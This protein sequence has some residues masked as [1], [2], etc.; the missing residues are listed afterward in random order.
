VKATHLARGGPGG[1]ARS[2]GLADESPP[3]DGIAG[4]GDGGIAAGDADGIGKPD[5]VIVPG[6]AAD[7]TSMLDGA[8]VSG[9]ACAATAAIGA[10]QWRQK[11]AGLR[12]CRL[13]TEH[14]AASSKELVTLQSL[15]KQKLPQQTQACN[16]LRSRPPGEPR[17]GDRRE[18]PADT[19]NGVIMEA[20]AG[21]GAEPRRAGRR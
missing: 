1:L 6:P 11:L 13:Q 4:G 3:A 17:I 9:P 19:E 7:R 8:T 16:G 12:Y 5:E 20:D 18:I 15:P 2:P 21:V 14:Q 10:P